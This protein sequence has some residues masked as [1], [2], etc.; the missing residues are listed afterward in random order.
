VED[1]NHKYTCSLL[2]PIMS[3]FNPLHIFTDLNLGTP[4]NFTT[5]WC[6]QTN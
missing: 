4:C 1:H 3:H 6:H 5:L 2:D